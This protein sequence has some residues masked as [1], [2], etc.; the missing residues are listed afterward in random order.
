[1]RG[2]STR[3]GAT[4]HPRSLLYFLDMKPT[5]KERI[6]TILFY[7]VMSVAWL[8]DTLFAIILFAAFLWLWMIL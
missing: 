8:L 6:V 7:G 4:R 2:Q 5:L 3:A 1:M